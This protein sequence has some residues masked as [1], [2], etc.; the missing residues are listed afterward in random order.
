M[1]LSDFK[2]SW[3]LQ[4]NGILHC[5]TSFTFATWNTLFSVQLNVFISSVWCLIIVYYLF[6]K[7]TD[8]V[9]LGWLKKDW[10]PKKYCLH[11]KFFYLSTASRITLSFVV[12]IKIA[13]RNLV[14]FAQFKK[15]DK[16]P[17]RTVT[18]SKIS[19]QL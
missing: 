19:L 9:L 13:L 10:Q 6:W 3:E 17:W 1:L 18:F 8:M 4:W 16:K 15:R 5:N 12:N 14:P 2:A 7:T 11:S